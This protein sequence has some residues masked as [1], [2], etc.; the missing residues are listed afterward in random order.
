[1]CSMDSIIKVKNLSKTI[2]QNEIL[3]NL[4]FTIKEGSING[5][6][7][8]NGSGKTT[9]I[10]ILNGVISPTEGEIE[11]LGVSPES[12]GRLIREQSGIVT[13]TT[14]LYHEMSAWDNLMFFSE[15]YGVSNPGRA[16]ELLR[17]FQM[18]EHKDKLVGSFSTGM[19]K[20]VA[21]AK[22]LLP[23]PKI[24]FLDEPTN[25]LDP[26]GIH[27]VLRH[28]K[29][30]NQREGITIIICSHVLQ[31]LDGFCD[32]YIFLKNGHLIESG[33]RKEI[34]KRHIREIDLLVETGLQIDTKV[35]NGFPYER[36]DET[37]L[38]FKLKGV[39]EISTLLAVILHDSWVHSC[40]VTNNSL[41]H[42]YFAVGGE[43]HE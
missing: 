33:Q 37:H 41:D 22:A 7:G 39:Q 35:Y 25:G 24:L 12:D 34:E 5:L 4:S 29:E 27:L 40:N 15:M 13:E 10:R 19:K 16:E 20:R 9:M 1:M 30:L 2:G 23:N 36:I 26:E 8:P 18:W 32:S 42:L 6:L 21:L 28:L 31:Q 14:N 43:Q 17:S 38:Q 3:T 11:V